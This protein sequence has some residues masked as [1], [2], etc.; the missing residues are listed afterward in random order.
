MKKRLLKVAI[1]TALT[2]AFAVPAFANPFSDVPAKHWAYDAVNKL[3]KAGIVDGFNDGTFRGEK[4]VTRYEMAQIVVKAMNKNMGPDQKALVQKL[5]Q[6]YAAEMK[7]MGVKVDSLQNQIDNMVKFSGDARVRYYNADNV[8][9]GTG[10]NAEEYRFRLGATAKVNDDITLYGRVTTGN[11][12]INNALGTASIDAA[13]AETTILG[14]DTVIG[15]QDF[16]LGQ[17][18]LA[19][20]G[21]LNGVTVK[22]GAWMAFAGKESDGTNMEKAYG[23][24]VNFK[25]GAPVVASYLTLG[26]NHY[27]SAGTGF[28]FLGTKI[29]G[30][31]A[32]NSTTSAK[33]YQVKAGLGKTG[34]TVGYKDIDAGALPY[35]SV[36]NLKSSIAAPALVDFYTASKTAHVKGMEYEYNTDLAKN[37]NLNVLYQSIK[38]GGKNVRAT[39][40]VA[41]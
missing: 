36:L 16:N 40:N 27:Y 6:E 41:F 38:D 23:G 19:S 26:S 7:D 34:L 35:D 12:N 33:G 20:N 39:V 14:M 21:N 37:T 32:K 3:A 2:V 13:N 9:V 5:A 1:T 4:T 18:L 8:G 11:Q 15:R 25:L 29:T 31:Y 17:G 22:H 30:E 10:G 28:N 24:Q